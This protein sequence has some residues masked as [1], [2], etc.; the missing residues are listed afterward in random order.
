MSTTNARRPPKQHIF[1]WQLAID[2]ISYA[3]TRL[4]PDPAVA[5]RAFRLQKAIDQG[6]EVYDVHLSP[7]GWV[8]CDCPGHTRWGHCKHAL[9]MCQMGLLAT[10]PARDEGY[11][12]RRQ[13]YSRLEAEEI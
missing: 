1:Q 7:E 8:S 2:G 13:W 4:D 6:G 11:E 9:A 5:S 12:A 3:V 10:P